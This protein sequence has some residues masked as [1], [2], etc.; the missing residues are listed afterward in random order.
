MLTVR[1]LTFTYAPRLPGEA[2]AHALQ[3]CSFDLAE[4]ASLAVMGATGAGKSTLAHVLTGLAPR[5]TGGRVT[6]LVQVGGVD[7]TRHPP[8]AGAIGILF[9]DAA[10]QLFNTSVEDEVAWGLEALNVPPGVIGERVNEALAR[11]DLAGVRRRAPWALSGGQQ[12][13]LAL[14]ALWA[15]QPRIL[16]LDEPLGGL[17]PEGRAEVMESVAE[18]NRTGTTLLISTLRLEVAQQMSQ[19]AFLVEGQMAAPAPAVGLA[20]MLPRLVEMG[21]LFPPE[22]W[23]DLSSG[24]LSARREPALEMENLHFS[25]SDGVQVLHGVDLVIPAGQFVA[26]VGRNG[27]GKS[28]LVRHFNGLLRPT[29]GSVRV[30]GKAILNR[31]TGSL[32]HEVGYLFQRPEQQLFAS[33]VRDELAYGPARLGLPDIP[34][35][36]QKTLT[37]FGLNEIA[38]LPPA[39]LGYGVQR[40]V[41]LAALAILE[42]PV[43]ILDEPTVGLDGRGIARLMHWLADLRRRD[44]TIVLVTHEMDMAHCA[45]RV[46]V[47]D[48]GEIMADGSPDSVL[49]LVAGRVG[50]A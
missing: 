47:L 16:V 50:V 42:T 20:D 3:A 8:E 43:V 10:T 41:T 35:R 5:Y 19:V 12:K 49:T 33:T 39:L 32:A 30:H 45:E 13:R 44:A 15:M 36:L 9:Q 21:V 4:A 22:M 40:T 37:G 34:A 14:A 2:P 1:D 25:Y 28:T 11:F 48:Q 23:P 7:V 46:V 29:A 31:P 27:A 17:D 26:I 18:L 38:D 6:G 24:G